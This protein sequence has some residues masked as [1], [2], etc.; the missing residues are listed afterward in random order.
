MKLK[1]LFLIL[2]C[3][4]LAS[5]PAL[6]ADLMTQTDT[7]SLAV[8]ST[9]TF[10][11]F[12]DISGSFTNGQTMAQKY[13]IGAKTTQLPCAVGGFF[14]NSTA[15]ASNVTFRIAGSVDGSSWTNGAQVILLS[16]PGNTTNWVNYQF[17]ITQP[18]PFYALRTIENTNAAAITARA[19]TLYFTGLPKN[20]L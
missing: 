6:G 15:T 16:V 12:G 14:T 5:L 7:N 2:S 1:K 4:A 13:I 19:N 20:G 11:I 8:S 3:V 17:F 10:K 18:Y 9:N